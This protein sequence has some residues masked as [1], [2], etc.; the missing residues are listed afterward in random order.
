MATTVPLS[1]VL[2]GVAFL[3]VVVAGAYL[4]GRGSEGDP[5]PL[6]EEEDDGTSTPSDSSSGPAPTTTSRRTTATTRPTTSTTTTSTPTSSAS[7]PPSTP[8]SM[9][10]EEAAD[11]L[12]VTSAD[13][14][15][16]WVSVT[17]K[18][19]SCSQSEANVVL[20]MGKSPGI[21]NEP[22]T[23]DGRVMN[24]ASTGDFCGPGTVVKGPDKPLVSGDYFRVCGFVDIFGPATVTELRIRIGYGPSDSLI[25]EY[26][27]QSVVGCPP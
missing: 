17:V 2:L 7:I 19:L 5:A 24:Q 26:R 21:V 13:P 25:G 18:L 27:I 10:V 14:D 4:F 20:R 8:F 23:K 1:A 15:L 6:V 9:G 22:A 16:T 3:A 11:G 12:T